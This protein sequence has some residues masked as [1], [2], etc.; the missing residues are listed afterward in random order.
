MMGTSKE[1][2]VVEKV[3]WSVYDCQVRV[4]MATCRMY[5]PH[6]DLC[7][8]AFVSMHIKTDSAKQR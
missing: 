2:E 6:R 4:D 3:I 5:T 1:T 7:T 8:S